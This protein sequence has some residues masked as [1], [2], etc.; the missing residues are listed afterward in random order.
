[1][2]CLPTFSIKKNKYRYTIHGCYGF[3][4]KRRNLFGSLF[5]AKHQQKLQIV[6]LTLVISHYGS[7]G[8]LYAPT[9]AIEINHSC[10]VYWDYSDVMWDYKV[11]PYHL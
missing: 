6:Q 11:G 3:G 8:L 10:E 2:V 5:V 4:K 7:M 1:M 9:I